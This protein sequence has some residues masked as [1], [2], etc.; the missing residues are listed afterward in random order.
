M[1]KALALAL[2]CTIVCLCYPVCAQYAQGAGGASPS[3]PDWR[4]AI[5]A[6]T[7]RKL[8]FFE[9]VDTAAKL[10]VKYIEAYPGQAIGGGIGGKTHFSMPAETR[11]QIKAKLA[12]AGVK[13]VCYGVVRAKGEKGWRQLFEFAKDMGI[14]TIT[15]EPNPKEMDVVEKLCEEFG[16]SVAIH[17]HPKPS[18]YWSPDTVLAA[19]KGRSKRIGA[20]ADTGHWAR[21][22]LDPVECLKKLEGRIISLHFK[23]I[24]KKQRRGAHDVPWGTGVCNASGMLAELKRQGFKG[25]FSIEYEH[26]TPQLELDVGKCVEYFRRTS[27]LPMEELKPAV[28]PTS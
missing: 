6:W 14:E 25:V 16:I 15:S 8:T 26:L 21:S 3:E 28:V 4:L 19:C 18:R 13:W 10:G 9:A 1:P 2:A 22:G 23:D 27:T 12:A 20:C 24:N 11:Q 5:Q 17:N 7:F